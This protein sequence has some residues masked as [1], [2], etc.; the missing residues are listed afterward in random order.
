MS[1]CPAGPSDG[2][3]ATFIEALRPRVGEETSEHG[4]CADDFPHNDHRSHDA[5]HT[6]PSQEEGKHAS[7]ARWRR[8]P[9]RQLWKTRQRRPPLDCGQVQLPSSPPRRTHHHHLHPQWRPHHHR[10]ARRPAW[11]LPWA[12]SLYTNKLPGRRCKTRRKERLL[13]GVSS[14]PHR[15]LFYI[16]GAAGGSL[17]RRSAGARSSPNHQCHKYGGATRPPGFTCTRGTPRRILSSRPL[18]RHDTQGSKY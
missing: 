9:R 7:G 14:H 15:S 3:K 12:A 18:Y 10:H 11:S 6:S 17:W 2:V 4:M 5:S 8:R 13:V 16:A 1:T